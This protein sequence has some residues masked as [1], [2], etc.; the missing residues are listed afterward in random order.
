MD[1][2]YKE[3]DSVIII[4]TKEAECHV[5]IGIYYRKI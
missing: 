1:K 2:K 4:E 5:H 3:E